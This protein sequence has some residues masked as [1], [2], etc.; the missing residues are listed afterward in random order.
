MTQS[1]NQST[2]AEMKQL[3]DS[4]ATF[5]VFL[6]GACGATECW[7]KGAIALLET[8]NLVGF[9]PNISDWS[10]EFAAV[11]QEA[12]EQVSVRLYYIGSSTLGNASIVEAVSEAII[13]HFENDTHVVVVL[14]NLPAD[15]L[16]IDTGKG[17][18]TISP[19]VADQVNRGRKYA[20]NALKRVGIEYFED[21]EDAIAKCAQIANDV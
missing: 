9:D 18:E 11:E 4:G 19:W 13:S 10:D 12:K 8:H 17:I 6:G 7:R 1:K 21:L 3:L 2:F 15:G 16:T 5:D 14:E 20:R